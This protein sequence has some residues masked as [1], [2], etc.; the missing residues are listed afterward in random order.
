M[1]K[2]ANNEL[3]NLKVEYGQ[4]EVTATIKGMKGTGFSIVLPGSIGLLI[5]GIFTYGLTILLIPVLIWWVMFSRTKIVFS[6]TGTVSVGRTKLAMEDLH[7]FHVWGTVESKHG[8]EKNQST[9]QRDMLAY[10]YGRR[11]YK[12]ATTVPQGDGFDVA[13]ELQHILKTIKEELYG[14]K[15]DVV[16]PNA[17]VE[18]REQKF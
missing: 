11:D 17:P 13:E 5:F 1:V 2:K 6:N 7:D 15:S 3:R 10:T 8:S 16:S 4:G 18:Q 12:I 9:L 14:D